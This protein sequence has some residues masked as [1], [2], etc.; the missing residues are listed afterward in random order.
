MK[1]DKIQKTATVSI[2]QNKALTA[3]FDDGA[4]L[5]IDKDGDEYAVTA[6]V[7]YEYC[8]TMHSDRMPKEGET[9]SFSSKETSYTVKF[10][11]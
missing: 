2:A 4:S 11:A 10:V 8:T 1:T 7:P 3:D 6:S 9:I 5:S